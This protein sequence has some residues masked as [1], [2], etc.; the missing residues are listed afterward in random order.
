MNGP[1]EHHNNFNLIR[2]VA[3]AQVLAVHG[4]NHLGF[5]GPLVMALKVVPGVPTFF[6]ISGFLICTSYERMQTNGL[7]A[8]FTNR[9]LRIYPALWTCVVVAALA[10]AAT[11]Y[12]S[13]QSFT[14]AHLLAWLLGQASFFQFYNPDFMR[15]FGV[16]VI[17]GALWTV[18]VELQFYALMPI[19]YALLVRNRR[20]LALVFLLSLALNVYFRF[21]LDWNRLG[22]KLLYV[23]WLPWVYM[24]ILGCVA[25]KYHEQ[26]E[27]LKARLQLRW[28]VP[29][30]VL[31]MVFIGS[32]EANAANSI[33]PI[34]FL[35]LAGCL[36][37]LSTQRLRLPERLSRFVARNDLSY[38]LYLY[39]M[40][41]INLLI[42]LGW[43]SAH[44]NLLAAFVVSGL[45]ATLS[46]FLIERPALQYKR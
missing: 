11:G 25:A 42:Y 34:S 45:A 14:L 31:S 5:E 22:A 29:A 9:I 37:K 38:G 32:Y 19:L 44:A 8:F 26:T 46:W 16:G 21:H 7:R 24:F 41:V 23:S 43:F 39:H 1:R 20:W 6:F 15:A 35:L 40:P 12:L 17:N 27:R 4:L 13:T 18:T 33:N 2:L 30:Y 28:L 36:L 10:V 3:A